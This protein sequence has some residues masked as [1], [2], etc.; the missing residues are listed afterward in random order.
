MS[1]VTPTSSSWARL[2]MR[3]WRASN[4]FTDA[5]ALYDSTPAV[6][7]PV[8]RPAGQ[9]VPPVDNLNPLKAPTSVRA[10]TGGS[11]QGVKGRAADVGRR[12]KVLGGAWP[13]PDSA[14]RAASER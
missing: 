3:C 2:A 10:R 4:S 6:W 14:G 9:S 13:E 7:R 12:T 5:G 1:A 8:G 11:F